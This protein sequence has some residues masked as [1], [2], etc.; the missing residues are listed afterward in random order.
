MAEEAIEI[1]DF[2][3]KG[4]YVIRLDGEEAELTFSRAGEHLIIIDHTGVP[5]A[6]RGKGT[7]L[8]LVERAVADARASG[9]AIIPLCPFAASKFR[10]HPEWADVLSK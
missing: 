9:K 10:E 4:R 7:G 3:Q 1:E 2:G 8:K 6:F 5:P